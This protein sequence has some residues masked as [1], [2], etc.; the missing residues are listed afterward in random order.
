MIRFTQGQARWAPPLTCLATAFGARHM[1]PKRLFVPCLLSFLVA[2][3]FYKKGFGDD[4]LGARLA[5]LGVPCWLKAGAEESPGICF[6][7]EVLK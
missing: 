5:S 1:A 7:G 4:N 2:T 6:Q 3:A